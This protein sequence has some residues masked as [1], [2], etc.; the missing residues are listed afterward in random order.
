[1][2]DI[3]QYILSVLA[4]SLASAIIAKLTFKSKLNQTLLKIACGVFVIITAVTPV[5]D[6]RISDVADMIGHTDFDAEELV[7]EALSSA[8]SEKISIIKDRIQ[9]YIKNKAAAYGADIIANVILS[10]EDNLTP[11]SVVIEGD[12]TP[13]KKKLLKK[14]IS[15]DLGIPEDAQ[16]WK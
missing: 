5:L 13:Y 1:M 6:F 7:E 9:A 10:E 4:A 3:K 14:I 15:E 11:E 16:V 12:I 8:E 2:N